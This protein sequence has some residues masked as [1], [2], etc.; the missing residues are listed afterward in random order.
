MKMIKKLTLVFLACFVFVISFVGDAQAA[1][2]V[3][4]G[5]ARLVDDFEENRLQKL[6]KLVR[7]ILRIFF[8]IRDQHDED[9]DFEEDGE[10]MDEE[11]G[12]EEEGKANLNELCD[13]VIFKI[14]SFFDKWGDVHCL[15]LTEKRMPGLFF[16]KHEKEEEEEGEEEEKDWLQGIDF[17]HLDERVSL[18]LDLEN[19]SR[20]SI[21]EMLSKGETLRPYIAVRFFDFNVNEQDDETG[22]ALLHHTVRL[23]DISNGFVNFLVTM[24]ADTD[25]EN[26]DGLKAF[27][28]ARAQGSDKR[29]LRVLGLA[30]G[31]GDEV[32][33]LVAPMGTTMGKI[34]GIFGGVAV[35]L[36]VVGGTGVV[37]IEVLERSVV[38]K[39]SVAFAVTVSVLAKLMEKLEVCRKIGYVRDR[40]RARGEVV[41][42]RVGGVIGRIVGKIEEDIIDCDLGYKDLIIGLGLAFVAGGVGGIVWFF[43]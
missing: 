13:D 12:T 32:G 33:R 27:D 39:T 1:R 2:R 42:R 21:E 17:A 40:G 10:G 25:L 15:L 23:E 29:R 34:M 36:V 11:E 26:Q 6:D 35:L 5:E 41:G 19:I 18:A 43:S 22:N 14:V 7:S 37:G 9:G 8:C 31:R 20:S 30:R 28:L 24:G 3:N 16:R 4:V 38:A